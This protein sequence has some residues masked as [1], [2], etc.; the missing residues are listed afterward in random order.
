MKFKFQKGMSVKAFDTQYRSPS[1]RWYFLLLNYLSGGNLH[2]KEKKKTFQ[3]LFLF[4]LYTC[5]V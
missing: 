1:A 2:F 4:E 3:Y 5:V